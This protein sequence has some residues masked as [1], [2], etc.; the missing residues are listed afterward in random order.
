MRTSLCLAFFALAALL[1]APT[2]ARAQ[3][4]TRLPDASRRSVGLE[5]GLE[6]AF[7]ARAVYTQR[8]ALGGL[9]DARIQARFTLPVV[10]PDLGDV[11]L[12][13]SL[14]A[15][16]LAWGDVR[17]ALLA[18]PVL[19]VSSNRVFTGAS[20]GVGATL[21]VGYE[22]PRWGLSAEA[23]YEQT[24]TTYIR[25]SDLY[26]Q[27]SHADARDGWYAFSGSTARVGLRAGV[28]LGSVEISARGGID[29]TGQFHSIL[30]PYY[31][32]LGGACAF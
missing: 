31:A 13:G 20:F 16:L 6:H 1:F 30:P 12:D 15:T 9:R 27:V 10:T 23:G 18:G 26:R 2:T 21:L 24:L 3:E 8:V 29:A 11:S 7:I 28:R 22:G 19:K 17:L 5:A 25:H 32:T 14:R 4:A